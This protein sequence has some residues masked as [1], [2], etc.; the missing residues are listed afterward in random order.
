MLFFMGLPS[1]ARFKDY[2]CSPF[3]PLPFSPLSLSHGL[4]LP[5]HS[6][7]C[8]SDSGRYRGVWSQKEIPGTYI[9]IP[10]QGRICM[11][12]TFPASG[13]S[14][15]PPRSPDSPPAKPVLILDN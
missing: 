10:A 14:K 9:K 5:L 12:G 4:S 11:Q 1:T 13:L 15:K 7:L 8:Y 6:C 2:P 3:C